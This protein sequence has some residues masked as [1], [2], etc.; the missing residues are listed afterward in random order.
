MGA[1]WW[2][3]CSEFGSS[4]VPGKDVRAPLFSCLCK[5]GVPVS[6]GVGIG[7]GMLEGSTLG[8]F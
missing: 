4:L 2:G 3:Q 5:T 1:L 7:Q 6:L 8:M